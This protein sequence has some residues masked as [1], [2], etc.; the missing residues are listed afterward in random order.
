MTILIRE[1]KLTDLKAWSSLWQAYLSFYHSENLAKST[2]DLLWQ[3]IHTLEHPIHCLVAQDA[4]KELVGLV[5]FFNHCDTWRKNDVCYLEDLYVTAKN[6]NQGI[7]K[8]L[9][10]AVYQQ[11]IDNQWDKLYWHTKGDNRQARA[12]YDQLTGGTDGFISYRLATD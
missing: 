4:N 3:R 9:I 6:R 12:L 10:K 5:H 1:T 8:A 7:G 11:A 2:S